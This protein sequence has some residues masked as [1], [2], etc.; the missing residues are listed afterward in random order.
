MN[1]RIKELEHQIKN[2]E[3][4]T[5]TINESAS[6]FTTEIIAETTSEP[7]SEFSTEMTTEAPK[8]NGENEQVHY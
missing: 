2:A 4:I 3:V 6:E 5:E 8:E 1:P 7:V